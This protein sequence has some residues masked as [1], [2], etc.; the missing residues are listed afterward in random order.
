MVC[1]VA[2]AGVS[3][4][5]YVSIANESPVSPARTLLERRRRLDTSR[6]LLSG[7]GK[8]QNDGPDYTVVYSVPMGKWGSRLVRFRV[9]SPGWPARF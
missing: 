1:P 4:R 8:L 2:S 7:G 9:G 6:G 5:E 3:L